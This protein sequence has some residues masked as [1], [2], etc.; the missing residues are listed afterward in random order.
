[1]GYAVCFA[2]PPTGQLCSVAT[3]RNISLASLGCFAFKTLTYQ[4]SQSCKLALRDVAGPAANVASENPCSLCERV[5]AR[6][7]RQP[8]VG[9]GIVN[10]T[11]DNYLLVLLSYDEMNKHHGKWS[12]CECTLVSTVC[13]THILEARRELRFP[14][15][16][17]LDIF[18]WMHWAGLYLDGRC[19]GSSIRRHSPQM[20]SKIRGVEFPRSAPTP[21][22]RAA[23]QVPGLALRCQQTAVV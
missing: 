18:Q 7:T 2:H 23:D 5:A 10:I 16:Y 4:T 1:M 11:P 13:A 20:R 12:P 19:V 9:I 3:R 14:S 8:R 6:W 21:F 17:L 22:P 15:K